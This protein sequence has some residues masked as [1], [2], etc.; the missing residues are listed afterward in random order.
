MMTAQICHSEGAN[1]TRPKPVR[2]IC[3]GIV[4]GATA[5]EKSPAQQAAVHYIN[6]DRY[7]QF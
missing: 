2:I 5:I 4:S 7:Q 6:I 3:S 1:R